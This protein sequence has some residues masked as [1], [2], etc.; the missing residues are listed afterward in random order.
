MRMRNYIITCLLLLSIGCKSRIEYEDKYLPVLRASDVYMPDSVRIYLAA[1]KD[2]NKEIAKGYAKQSEEM[3]AANIDKAVYASKRAVTLYPSKENYL[4]LAERLKQKGD[5][6]ELLKLYYFLTAKHSLD[7]RT[8][9]RFSDY[10]FEKPG[11]DLLYEYFIYSSLNRDYFQ[12]DEDEISLDKAEMRK[13]LLN[14]PRIK[15]EKTSV[16][17]QNILLQLLSFD[18]IQQYA[19]NPDAFKTFLRSIPDSS[20]VFSIDENN[21]F[22]FRYRS[23]EESYEDEGPSI[24]Y[25]FKTMRLNYLY[26]R[27]SDSNHYVANVNFLKRYKLNNTINAVLYAVDSSAPTCPTN[28]RHIYYRL[29]TYGAD[30]KIIDQ[31][32][33]A[34]QAG[35]IFTTASVNKNSFTI[36]ENHRRWGK[37]YEYDNFDNELLGTDKIRSANYVIDENGKIKESGAMQP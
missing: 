34:S 30:A 25:G 31:K 21:I 2:E 4:L 29:V 17:F 6:Q 23:Q 18:E 16:E 19:S 20:G 10:V 27:Q 7:L 37:P 15:F 13:R 36:T 9:Q 12:I 11:T 33:I 32:V 35:E 3:A 24:D 28:M 1:H 26:E 14:D 8:G 5:L 22:K